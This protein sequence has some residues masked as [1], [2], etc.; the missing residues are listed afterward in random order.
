MKPISVKQVQAPLRARY[1]ADPPAAM[2]TDRACTQST[3]ES[4]PFHSTVLPMPG[5]GE[6]LPVGVHRALGGLHDAPT[7]GDILCAAWASCLD[8]SLRMVAN[9][10]GISLVSLKV[11]VEGEVDVRGTLMVER[12]IPVGFQRMVCSVR[13]IAAAGTP[14]AA[15]DKL[16]KLAEHCC[17]VQQTLSH[18]PQLRTRYERDGSASAASAA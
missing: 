8:S 16:C 14:A 5:C 18:P 9:A 1:R 4:D 15:V 6:S 11:E 7:P 2:V 13:L 12:E 10:M 3:D 17:V